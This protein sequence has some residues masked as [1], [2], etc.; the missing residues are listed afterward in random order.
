MRMCCST[1]SGAWYQT[2][3]GPVRSVW[4]EPVE[5]NRLRSR[6]GVS[7]QIEGQVVDFDLTTR[8]H[9]PGAYTLR[10]AIAQRG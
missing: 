9:D 1:G 4:L 5:R 10:L 7:S 6:M 2:I 8:I 3:S